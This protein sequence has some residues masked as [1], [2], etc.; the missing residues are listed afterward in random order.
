MTGK[1]LDIKS[2]SSSCRLANLSVT[3]RMRRVVAPVEGSLFGPGYLRVSIARQ[4]WISATKGHLGIG[5]RFASTK[6]SVERKTHLIKEKVDKFDTKE[7]AFV[8]ISGAIHK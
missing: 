4:I 7:I 8:G 6:L 5:Q 2:G 3:F 1:D